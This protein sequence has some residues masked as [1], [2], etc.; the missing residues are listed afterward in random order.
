MLDHFCLEAFARTSVQSVSPHLGSDSRKL[1]NLCL[2]RDVQRRLPRSRSGAKG[3]GG[4]VKLAI[5][6]EM[7]LAFA[8]AWGA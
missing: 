5:I 3:G 2:H 7:S 1:W 8:I 6:A 4:A